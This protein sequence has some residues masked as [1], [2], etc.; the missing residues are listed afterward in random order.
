MM[1]E[2]ALGA[3]FGDLGQDG[4]SAW[5]PCYEAEDELCGALDL[6]GCNNPHAT[7]VSERV[8]DQVEQRLLRIGRDIEQVLVAIPLARNAKR[9]E[10]ESLPLWFSGLGSADLA[11]ILFQVPVMVAVH[12]QEMLPR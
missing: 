12:A 2:I 4:V 5:S 1:A 9:A 8:V 7:F 10:D 11:Y 3:L 6:S